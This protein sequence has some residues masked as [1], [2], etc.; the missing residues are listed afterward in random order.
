VPHAKHIPPHAQLRVR[1]CQFLA[2]APLATAY[3]NIQVRPAFNA[4][5]LV[6]T[7]SLGTSGFGPFGTPVSGFQLQIWHIG[8]KGQRQLF[9]TSVVSPAVAGSAANPFWLTD[10]ELFL[11]GDSLRIQV[12]NLDSANSD[13]IWVALWGGELNG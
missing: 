1:S 12:K 10:T 7:D 6:A 3:Q 9:N 8:R 5:A 2:V 13:S 4:W 11:D